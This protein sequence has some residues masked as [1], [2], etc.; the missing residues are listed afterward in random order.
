LLPK[1]KS[2]LLSGYADPEYIEQLRKY[3]YRFWAWVNTV[4]FL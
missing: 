4:V 3:P 2:G 1:S